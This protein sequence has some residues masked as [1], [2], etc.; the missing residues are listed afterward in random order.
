MSQ[1]SIQTRNLLAAL[2]AAVLSVSRPSVGHAA[3][4]AT[5]PWDETLDIVQNFLIGP[6]AHS[7]IAISVIAAS[8]A[9]AVAGDSK[10]ARHLAKAAVGSAVALVA[11]ELMN[12]L[13]L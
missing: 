10:L 7:V 3:T 6:V 11:V 9:Y 5:L 8:L 4:Q 13:L 1:A 2:I 12:Y